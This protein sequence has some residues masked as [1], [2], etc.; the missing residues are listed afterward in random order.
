[1]PQYPVI[2]WRISWDVNNKFGR[3]QLN[4]AGAP[5]FN[6]PPLP[7]D[8]FSAVSQVLIASRVAASPLVWDTATAE[9][10]IQ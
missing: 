9:L 8:R 5:P 3:V 10:M 2:N 7:A 6:L 1:M 4:F